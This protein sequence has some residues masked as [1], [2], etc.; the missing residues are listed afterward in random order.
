MLICNMPITAKREARRHETFPRLLVVDKHTEHAT[1]VCNHDAQA[2]VLS[3]EGRGTMVIEQNT[4]K[5]LE[6]T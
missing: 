5:S 1:A 3:L 2:S 4:I 6:D